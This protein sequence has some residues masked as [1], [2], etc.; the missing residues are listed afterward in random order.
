MQITAAT[1]AANATRTVRP[2]F[3][4]VEMAG[5]VPAG[6]VA[7]QV[8]IIA[9]SL[10]ALRVAQGAT[11]TAWLPLSEI[12]IERGQWAR[13]LHEGARVYIPRRMAQE[14]GIDEIEDRQMER[15]REIIAQRSTS[16]FLGRVQIVDEISAYMDADSA[17]DTGR[18][19]EALSGCTFEGM[20]QVAQRQRDG[21]RYEVIAIDPNDEATPAGRAQIGAYALIEHFA[22]MMQEGN[23]AE[24]I[25]EC[26]HWMFAIE[27]QTDGMEPETREAILRVLIRARHA[28]NAARH[29]EP[30]ALVTPHQRAEEVRAMRAHRTH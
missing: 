8:R 27:A 6:Y 20:E 24:I 5:Y 28:A 26:K 30:C 22:E 3:R 19:D 16:Q 1:I 14:A 2:M 17:E 29:G 4:F 9:H 21:Y 23:H 25:R 11:H 13:D 18:F 15:E 10:R 12:L 7:A